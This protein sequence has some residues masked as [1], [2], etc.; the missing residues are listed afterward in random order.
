MGN[1]DYSLI[2]LLGSGVVVNVVLFSGSSLR[3]VDELRLLSGYSVLSCR[4]LSHMVPTLLAFDEDYRK[5]IQVETR[6]TSTSAMRVLQWRV[7][8]SH[9]PK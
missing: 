6:S 1:E 4:Y 2:R 8:L 7:S 3:M 9:T 5:P